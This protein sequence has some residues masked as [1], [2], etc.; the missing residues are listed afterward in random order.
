LFLHPQFSSVT[1][2]EFFDPPAFPAFWWPLSFLI[3][4]IVSVLLKFIAFPRPIAVPSQVVIAL[5]CSQ[6]LDFF[7]SVQLLTPPSLQFESRPD[8]TAYSFKDIFGRSNVPPPFGLLNTFPSTIEILLL[9]VSG[10]V[11]LL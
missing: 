9:I 6:N 7:P 8:P 3:C 10:S 5:S 11:S 2:L 4:P 1:A